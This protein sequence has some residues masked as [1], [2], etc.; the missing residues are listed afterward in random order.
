MN[1]STCFRMDSCYSSRCVPRG[2]GRSLENALTYYEFFAGGGMAR[3][4]LG[5]KWQCLFAN[6]FSPNKV[7]SYADNWGSED[8]H[9]G[10]IASVDTSKLPA[11]ATLAWASFPCQDLSLAGTYAGL[12]GVG[13]TMTR[14]GTFWHFW[15]LMKGLIHEGRKPT[16]IVL[17]NVIG[18]LTSRGGDDFVA[19]CNALADG[20]YRFGSVVV[21]AARFVPQSRPRVFFVAINGDFQVP[22]SL[23][24]D[25]PSADWH[26]LALTRAQ[27]LLEGLAR[28]NWLW[29]HMPQTPSRE[30]NLADIV[31]DSPSDV[32]WHSPLETT[33]LLAMMS[34]ANREKVISA[35]SE[36]VRVVGA[37]YRRTRPDQKGGKQQRAEVRFDGLAGCLRTPRG[38]SSRQTIIVVEGGSIRSRLL[39]SREAARLMGL[40]DSYRMP[41]RY[42]EA[43]HLAG[44]GVCVNV[45]RF[46]SSALLEPLAY[47][48]NQKLLIAAE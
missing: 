35:Q 5:Q 1:L 33:K 32:S 16:T 37:V 34:D 46:L 20:G 43:Y 14:S 18:A 41:R 23:L 21:D 26:P 47:A 44:D 13:A 38:G 30:L 11:R 8:I 28:E 19:I 39:S 10:D 42:N 24:R 12:G 6:D 17:E 45:V 4:G 7:A 15:S 27:S 36:G 9:L 25:G 22:D 2:G 29:W 40:P 31:E 3:A 48:E